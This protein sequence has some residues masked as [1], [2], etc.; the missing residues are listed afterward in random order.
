MK[1][2][3]MYLLFNLFI[4]KIVLGQ[5]ILSEIT[6][7]PSGSEQTNDS[8]AKKMFDLTVDTLYPIIIE[9]NYYFHSTITN[10][11]RH[12]IEHFSA[13]FF[14]DSNEDSVCHVS[15]IFFSSQNLTLNTNCSLNI[16]GE[17]LQPVS[18]I[19]NVGLLIQY[20][21]DENQNNKQKLI[22]LEISD[23]S[24]SLIIN[25][26]MVAPLPGDPEWIELYNPTEIPI[27]LAHW[28]LSDQDTTKKKC[29]TQE[30]IQLSPSEFLIITE[31]PFFLSNSVQWIQMALP[32]LN[33]DQD[34]I[35]LFDF[36]QNLIDCAHY[37]TSSDW[38]T[39]V[40]LERI[41]YYQSS[42]DS[43]NWMPSV[44][45]T[46]STPGFKNSVSFDKIPNHCRLDVSPNPFSPDGDKWEDVTCISYKVPVTQCRVIL[47]IYDLLGRPV[48][49]LF[50]GSRSGATGSVFWDGLNSQ[51]NLCRIGIYILY[52]Q[53]IDDLSGQVFEKKATIV[54]A[55][56][57]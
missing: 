4:F 54:L 12:S 9:E 10:T 48:H 1:T 19:K 42:K 5:I 47:Q 51:G 3:L 2:T 34:A 37:S 24:K 23:S 52:F 25:E 18:G 28:Y 36:K 6:I 27:D 16:K 41:Q 15:E 57:L 43:Q 49:T 32:S 29:I 40:S 50:G 30:S 8:L 11:G 35:Y 39:G 14:W 26:I 46:G 20:T 13:H 31:T 17:W 45:K 44:S 56:Q 53:A 55:R 33:N 22:S 38:E 21:G 7:N